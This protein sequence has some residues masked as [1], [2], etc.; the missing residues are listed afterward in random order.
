MDATEV[1][2]MFAAASTLVLGVVGILYVR[3]RRARKQA[4]MATS[5]T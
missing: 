5:R 1:F 4:T 2:L 3:R